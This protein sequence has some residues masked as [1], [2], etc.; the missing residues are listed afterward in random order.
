MHS[1][2]SYYN[3]N[4]NEINNVLLLLPINTLLSNSMSYRFHVNWNGYVVSQLFFFFSKNSTKLI[5][6]SFI[7]RNIFIFFFI[8]YRMRAITSNDNLV[9]FYAN[10]NGVFLGTIHMWETCN[11]PKDLI[12]AIFFWF[13]LSLVSRHW[14]ECWD[15]A[16]NH[17]RFRKIY[18]TSSTIMKYCS[19]FVKGQ[20]RTT[21][22][23]FSRYNW[24]IYSDYMC[25]IQGKL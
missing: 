14:F 18:Q 22:I 21:N 5:K 10:I 16:H 12:I 20:V 17:I 15:K 19:C 11:V 2:Q 24:K 25:K 9:I 1:H 6:I 4:N 7:R 3:H 8:V 23:T 13:S